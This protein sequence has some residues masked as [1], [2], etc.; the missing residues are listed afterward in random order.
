MPPGWNSGGR[1]GTLAGTLST[2]PLGRLA[3]VAPI[4]VLL[5]LGTLPAFLGLAVVIPL[6][7][8]ATWHLYR[9]TIEPELNP[10]P[11]PPKVFTYV[12]SGL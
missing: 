5:V 3:L 12:P 8:H 7:G 11:L 9:E 1:R 2:T 10:Q 6:L 4:A